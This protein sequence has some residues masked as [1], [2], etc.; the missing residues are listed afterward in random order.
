MLCNV[1]LTILLVRDVLQDID[2]IMATKKKAPVSTSK[3]KK[4]STKAVK[5][6]AKSAKPAPQPKKNASKSFQP[7]KKVAQIK[8][9]SIDAG[10]DS[11][12]TLLNMAKEEMSKLNAPQIEAEKAEKA[13]KLKPIK[14]ERGNLADE[15]AK[16][17]ELYKRHS[18]DKATNY[19][20][21]DQ[22]EASKPI[23]HK[24][25]GWGFI[26]TNENDRLEVLFQNGIKMLI[27]N[28]KAN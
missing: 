7:D 17:Q 26:L 22:F 2:K 25:L 15:K 18:K 12:D 8:K 10:L 24:V 6:A 4:T 14:V 23:N 1:K 11:G 20:M 28:Y 16:W 13:G 27:S 3:A 5:A 21:T 19:K 9:T